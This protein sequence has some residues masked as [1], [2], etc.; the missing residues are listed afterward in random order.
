MASFQV[1]SHCI[2]I[3]RE[4]ASEG[5]PTVLTPVIQ[6]RLSSLWR[7]PCLAALRIQPAGDVLA[8]ALRPLGADEQLAPL[9][10]HYLRLRAAAGSQSCPGADFPMA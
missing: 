10:A 4:F 2:S 1:E 9:C 6:P 7:T 3:V 8:R 5:L